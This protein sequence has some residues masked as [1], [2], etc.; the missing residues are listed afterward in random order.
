MHVILLG[1]LKTLRT[2]TMTGRCPTLT[3]GC[4]TGVEGGMGFPA[5]L[6]RPLIGTHGHITDIVFP[7]RTGLGLPWDL[8][9]APG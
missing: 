5:T 2:C 7:S 9:T 8:L 4:A 3:F 6:T 1:M